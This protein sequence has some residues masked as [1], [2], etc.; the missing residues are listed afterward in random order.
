MRLVFA[1]LLASA[2]TGCFW[3]RH[4]PANQSPFAGAAGNNPS[5]D[6]LIVTSQ[7]SLVGKIAHVN[8]ADRFV[9]LTF[10]VGHLPVMNQQ[11][12]VYRGGLKVGEIRVTG[13]QYD[14]NVVGDLVAGESQVGDEVRDRQ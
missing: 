12:G 9:V 1:A 14:D 2:L 5:G 10:P 7:H 8:V 6:K 13:P 11:L 3:K 4:A